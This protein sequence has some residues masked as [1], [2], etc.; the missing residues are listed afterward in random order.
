MDTGSAKRVPR[1]RFGGPYPWL[2]SLLGEYAFNT[3]ELHNITHRR[4]GTVRVHIIDLFFSPNFVSLLHGNVHAPLATNPGWR[5][6]VVTIRICTVPNNFCVNLS[7]TS[8]S[9][10]QFFN[11]NHSST[12]GNHETIAIFVKCAGCLLGCIVSCCRKRTHAVKH[13]CELPA[14][15]F[16]STAKSYVS[17]V[18]LDLLHASS[19]AMR[20]STAR[21][22]NAE[23]G[24]IDFK[25][26]RKHGTR[27]RSHR[28]SHSERPNPLCPPVAAALNSV[29]RLHNV[30]DA[31]STL[32]EDPGNPFVLLVLFFC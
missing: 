19:N 15:V 14:H 29:H 12:S 18:E 4:R 31:S 13:R 9:M 23:T 27:S 11:D 8:L 10:F 24:T 32:T 6:H 16:T 20:T 7:T 5:N 22:T 17:L 2:I 25:R 3:L 28:P 30:R 1:Q 26:S 21:T